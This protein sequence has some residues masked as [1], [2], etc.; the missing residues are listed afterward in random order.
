VIAAEEHALNEV[1]RA[2]LRHRESKGNERDVRKIP[3]SVNFCEVGTSIC[4]KN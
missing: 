4:K 3:A 1:E 2:A